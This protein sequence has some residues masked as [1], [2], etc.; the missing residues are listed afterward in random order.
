[1]PQ[2]PFK[3]LYL[4]LNYGGNLNGFQA[5]YS[6][7]FVAATSVDLSFEAVFLRNSCM[8]PGAC[9]LTAQLLVL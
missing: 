7:C 4:F 5:V 6:L 9:G 1:M 3:D 2:L 8:P